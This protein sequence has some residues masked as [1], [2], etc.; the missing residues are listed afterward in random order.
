[1]MPST[2]GITRAATVLLAL[3]LLSGCT[4][5]K[6]GMALTRSRDV[7]VVSKTNADIRYLAGTSPEIAEQVT[8]RVAAAVKEAREVVEKAHGAKFAH[9][10]Q[11][12]IC[13]ADCFIRY[14]PVTVNEPAAQFGDSIFLNIDAL[15]KREARGALP[16]EYILTHEL[17]HLLLY[18]VA[19]PIAYARVPAWFREGIA[20]QVAQGAGASEFVT[21]PEAARML[22]DGKHFD[23]AEVGSMLTNRTAPSYGLTTPMFYRQ[24]LMFVD[25]LKA[26]NPTAFEKALHDIVS[27]KDFHDSFKSAYGASIVSYWPAFITSVTAIMP[28]AEADSHW[29][30]QYFPV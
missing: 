10:P 15:L 8:N 27:G 24:A 18:Q 26:S 12:Y 19:G 2:S 7:F 20:Q 3:C 29:R 21:K 6:T 22:L 17:S 11:V 25:F 5:I 13:H 4:L 16:L 14:V 30:Y 23:P 1:M 9:A 28:L